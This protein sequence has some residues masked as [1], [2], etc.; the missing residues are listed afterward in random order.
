[1]LA[2]KLAE[3]ACKRVIVTLQIPPDALTN[4]DRKSVVV[5]ETAK[6][7]VNKVLVLKIEDEE[8]NSYDTATSSLYPEK[9]LT[10]TVGKL[11]KEPSFDMDLEKVYTEGIHIFLTR[12][13]AELYLLQF[14]PNGL[15]QMWH[16][17]GQKLYE[18]TYVNGKM[19]GLYQEWHENGK[20]HVE[21]K[22]VNGK[23]EGLFQSWHN[24]GQKECEIRYVNGIKNGLYECWYNNGQK[25]YCCMYVNGVKNGLQQFWYGNGKVKEKSM[26][27]N[28]LLDGLLQ[29]WHFNGQKICEG[30]YVKGKEVGV[31]TFW[32]VNGKK[33]CTVTYLDDEDQELKSGMK[34][35]EIT[36]VNGSVFGHH[37]IWHNGKMLYKKSY[38]LGD[39]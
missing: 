4:I 24:N 23:K 28:G 5:K 21:V 27:V 36:T 33:R 18:V 15:F 13:V 8:G 12:R 19:E 14:I 25:A 34:N 35:Y 16:D 31:F 3:Y 22:Y 11:I 38:W 10:Y 6:H 9:H 17:N 37:E 30:V 39:A 32:D 2:Y 26:W 29:H 20:K 1:M 7:R